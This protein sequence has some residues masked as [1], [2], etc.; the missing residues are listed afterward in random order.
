MK[1]QWNKFNKK[2]KKWLIGAVFL[3][4]VG[5]A[6]VCLGR[7]WLFLCIVVMLLHGFMLLKIIMSQAEL[8]EKLEIEKD[9]LVQEMHREHLAE[10]VGNLREEIMQTR[11]GRG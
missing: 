11:E 7:E 2:E 10:R 4:A 6:A 1:F 3:F 9:E 5:V 8:I